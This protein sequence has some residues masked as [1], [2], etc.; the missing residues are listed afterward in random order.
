MKLRVNENVKAILCSGLDESNKVEDKDDPQ[1]CFA[2][3]HY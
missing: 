2:S 3:W 1:T